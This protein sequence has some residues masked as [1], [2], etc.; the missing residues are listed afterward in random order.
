MQINTVEEGYN[1]LIEKITDLTDEFTAF[2]QNIVL[3]KT[4]QQAAPIPSTDRDQQSSI[5]DLY[6]LTGDKLHTP[7]Q[8]VVKPSVAEPPQTIQPPTTDSQLSNDEIVCWIVHPTSH[9]LCHETQEFGTYPC[10]SHK[11]VNVL[12]ESINGA[13]WHREE[14]PHRRTAPQRVE[15][16]R[17]RLNPRT[18]HP[19]DDSSRSNESDGAHQH[20]GGNRARRQDNS[21]QRSRTPRNIQEPSYLSTQIGEM[22]KTNGMENYQDRIIFGI[23][24]L[25]HSMVGVHQDYLDGFKSLKQNLPTTY[26]GNSN[27]DAFDSW[28]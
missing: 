11:S 27:L 2:R 18:T 20:R 21:S 1:K 19:T 7:T 4:I 5:D 16:T 3:D 25:I 13:H 26:S 24:Q 12:D 22:A 17:Y 8:S 10:Q 28:L 6:S 14:T 15:I 23:C 9:D